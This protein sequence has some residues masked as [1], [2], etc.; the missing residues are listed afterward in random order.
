MPSSTAATA[1]VTGV[2]FSG[3]DDAV[4]PVKA[5]DAAEVSAKA[6]FLILF[7]LNFPSHSADIVR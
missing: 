5:I 3:A 7:M 6:A 4:T 2:L 1:V